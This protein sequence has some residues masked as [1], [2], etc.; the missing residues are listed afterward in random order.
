MSVYHNTMSSPRQSLGQS[1]H[2]ISETTYETAI[3]RA[4]FETTNLNQYYIV[5]ANA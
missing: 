3:V 5:N 4:N 2:N 1:T